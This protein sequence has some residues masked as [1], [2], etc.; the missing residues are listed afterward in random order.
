MI[1]KHVFIKWDARLKHGVQLIDYQHKKLVTLTNTLHLACME[2][3]ETASR[4]FIEVARE[5]VNYVHYHFS[6]EEHMM[7]FLMYPNYHNHRM[8]H[9][10]FI[11]EILRQTRMF[12]KQQNLVPHRYVLFLKDWILSHIAVRDKSLAEHIRFIEDQEKVQ[13]IF[14]KPA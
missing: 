9:E 1:K 7:R 6:T 8:E 12:E 5:M 13:I 14:S 2:D 11:K 4:C 10:R 3:Q